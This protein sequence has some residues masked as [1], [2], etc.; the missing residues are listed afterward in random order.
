MIMPIMYQWFVHLSFV[1]IICS[2]NAITL[3]EHSPFLPQNHSANIAPV[4]VSQKTTKFQDSRFAFKGVAL[5]SGQYYF[6]ILDIQADESH[7]L[8]SDESIN[9]FKVTA[10]YADAGI[11]EYAFGSFSGQLSLYGEE[12]RVP[13]VL[14]GYETNQDE[15]LSAHSP[16]LTRTH[17]GKSLSQSTYQSTERVFRFPIQEEKPNESGGLII[18]SENSRASAPSGGRN[19]LFASQDADIYKEKRKEQ[20]IL[21]ETRQPIEAFD[22]PGRKTFPRFSSVNPNG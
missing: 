9:G 13:I 22:P 4:P 8:R 12:S 21:R 5:L 16:E 1:A 10:Y 17:S 2:A 19:E 3:I 20:E 18:F 11:I 6:S 7:W 15:R 14:L